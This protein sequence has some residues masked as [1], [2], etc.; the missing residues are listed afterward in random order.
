MNWPWWAWALMFWALV[1]ALGLAR[2]EVAG[3][4]LAV[5]TAAEIIIV[6]VETISGLAR[7]AGGPPGLR[8]AV[9]VNHDRGG[10]RDGG[11]A[12]GDRADRV[13]RLRAVPRAE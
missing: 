8:G 10:G 13:R 2:V 12:G 1:A 4:V 11:G 3:R 9:A 6:L 7:P 5:L